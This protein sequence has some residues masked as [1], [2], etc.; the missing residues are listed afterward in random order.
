MVLNSFEHADELITKKLY[1]DRPVPIILGELMGLGQVALNPGTIKGYSSLQVEAVI[2]F[3]DSF[4]DEL[5][6]M[7]EN[8]GKGM[9]PGA[10][11]VDTLPWLRH[12][13]SWVPFNSIHTIATEGRTRLLHVIGLPFEYVKQ[14]LASSS[15]NASFT[16]MGTIFTFLLAMALYPDIQ[17]KIR[18]E[19]DHVVGHETM[20][21]DPVVCFCL[22]HFTS[23][24]DIYQGASIPL[25]QQA[26]P[27]ISS[28]GSAAISRDSI[29]GIPPEEFAPE[30]FLDACV[31][32]TALD[33]YSY[34][35][36][37]AWCCDDG[38]DVLML[39]GLF[40]IKAPQCGSSSHHGLLVTQGRVQCTGNPELLR[41]SSQTRNFQRRLL[42]RL[43]LLTNTLPFSSSYS[44]MLV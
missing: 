35:Y 12:I 22:A 34:A 7:M 15:P 32:K 23:K 44:Q 9:M 30:R 8:I 13:P 14:Q 27:L 16:T 38:F 31:E 21:W 20:R 25:N 19:L 29:S 39:T 36:G 43:S 41:I 10:Y 11:L 24:E 1:S 5:E 26:S 6:I 3:L 18:M 40:N 2:L 28:K 4:I 17:T 33:P 42:K 37:G